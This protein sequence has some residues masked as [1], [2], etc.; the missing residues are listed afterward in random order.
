MAS[1]LD[2]IGNLRLPHQATTSENQESLKKHSDYSNPL[3]DRVST[4]IVDLFCKDEEFFE[5]LTKKLD[6]GDSFAKGYA[7][8]YVWAYVS[9]K[10][11]ENIRTTKDRETMEKADVE[12]LKTH[13]LASAKALF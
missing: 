13:M 6:R 8:G 5:A 7:E 3:S 11:R 2:H 1:S 4:E 12:M 10:D 9:G